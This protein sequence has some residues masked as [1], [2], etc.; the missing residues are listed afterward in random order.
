MTTKIT[1]ARKK[2]HASGKKLV[3][4]IQGTKHIKFHTFGYLSDRS[5][6]QSII[7]SNLKI[8]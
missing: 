7:H 6:K 1:I 3:T 5:I 4:V 2:D 8:V